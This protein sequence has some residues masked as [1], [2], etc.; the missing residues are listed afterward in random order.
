MAETIPSKTDLM[1]EILYNPKFVLLPS[2]KV[3][4]KT[5]VADGKPSYLMKNHATGTY[6]DLDTLTNL[7]RKLTD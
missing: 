1:Y 4:V 5:T 7:I 6:Y 2:P 3:N